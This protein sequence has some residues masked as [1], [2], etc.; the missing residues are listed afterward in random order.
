MA[1]SL[2]LPS[3]TSLAGNWLIEHD[4]KNC[5]V[6][7]SHTSLPQANGYQFAKVGDNCA[8]IVVPETVAWRPEPDGI[9]FLN[10]DG[11]TLM[12]FSGY[13][14]HFR[15]DDNAKGIFILSKK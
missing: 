6:T 13:E 11:A 8:D 9:A 7:L 10:A 4:K 5:V 15:L 1:S 3:A 12:F 2:S 14:P